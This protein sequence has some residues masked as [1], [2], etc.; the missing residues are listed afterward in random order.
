MTEA[1]ADF[2]FWPIYSLHCSTDCR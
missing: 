2:N 1:T